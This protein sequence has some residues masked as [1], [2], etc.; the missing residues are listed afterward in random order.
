MKKKIAFIINFNPDKW[1]GGMHVIKNLIF[2]IKKFSNNNI[3]AV[4]VV[5]KNLTKEELKMFE[6]LTILKTNFF[7]NESLIKKIYN[8]L[9][10]ILLGKSNDYEKFFSKEKIDFVSHIN[11][12]STNL[13]FGKKSLVKSLSFIP[14]LQHI[15]LKQN[16]SFQKIIMRNLNIFLCGLYSSKILLSGSHAKKDIKKISKT[17]HKKSV[18]SKFI[19]KCPEKKDIS[20][21]ATLKKIY[22]F[23]T[24]YFYLP[25]QYWVHKNH[26]VVLKALSYI[27]HKF[28][29]KKILIISS[30]N[31]EDYRNP[32]YI[33]KIKCYISKNNLKDYYHYI[34]VI[35]FKDVLS[36]MYHSIAVINPSKFE[37]RSS[38]VEQAKCMGKKIILSNIPVHKEQKPRYSKYF[39]VDNFKK[40]AHILMIENNEYNNNIN[41]DYNDIL[42]KN[43]QD[44]LNYYKAYIK[45]LSDYK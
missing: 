4:L 10:V 44:L 15:H 6:G 11:V 17:A 31:N 27:K 41:L 45:I 21:I 8:K 39:G 13:V 22:K 20:N 33:Q 29:L 43:N 36:L 38:T 42:K 19:F 24:P 37:G 35:P 7:Y 3:K 23:D 16:F 28:S 5:K 12:F 18:L 34:G 32:N 1:L 9:S 2:C 25:N 40:L 14:D 30:G 26:E